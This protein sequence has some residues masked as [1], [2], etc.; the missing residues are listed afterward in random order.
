MKDDFF[1]DM[2]NPLGGDK[3]YN[4]LNIL[5]DMYNDDDSDLDDET[6]CLDG[7]DWEEDLEDI[8][9]LGKDFFDD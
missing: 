6:D 8:L 2:L 5:Y 9:F 1:D 7:E 3:M 4:P